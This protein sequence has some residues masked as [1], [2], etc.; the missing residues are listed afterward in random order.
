MAKFYKA[1]DKFLR[2]PFVEGFNSIITVV[3]LS[4]VWRFTYLLPFKE[5]EWEYAK[6]GN[7]LMHYFLSL[8][9]IYIVIVRVWRFIVSRKNWRKHRLTKNF[10]EMTKRYELALN[11]IGTNLIDE[12]K[13]KYSF[14]KVTQANLNIAIDLAHKAW[15]YNEKG[16]CIRDK[17]FREKYFKTLFDS[18]NEIFY[19]IKKSDKNIGYSSVIPMSNGNHFAGLKD[20]YELTGDD[21]STPNQ[22]S[23]IYLQA[24]YIDD[25][26][27]N[28]PLEYATAIIC[29]LSQVSRNIADGNDITLYA[30][31][32]TLDGE[33]LLNKMGFRNTLRSSK[34]QFPKPIWDFYLAW[35]D[36]ELEDVPDNS[37]ITIGAIRKLQELKKTNL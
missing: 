14:E 7:E 6:L 1:I 32:F 10:E 29:M 36:S 2:N 15:D 18:N 4:I 12:D 27:R 26:W 30:E 28:R 8:L 5:E 3:L 34:N 22:S 23:L 21:I 35:K 31:Q 13:I 33:K 24:I 16:E 9:T 25:A 17:S 11:K 37:E 19:L 20:Q